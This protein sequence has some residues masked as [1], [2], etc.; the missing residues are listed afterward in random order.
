MLEIEN[1]LRVK[2]AIEARMKEM[3]LHLEQLVQ[4]KNGVHVYRVS[5]AN[6]FYYF[7]YFEHDKDALEIACYQGQRFP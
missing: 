5:R 3:G 6:K 1:N 2:E 7:K 4:V